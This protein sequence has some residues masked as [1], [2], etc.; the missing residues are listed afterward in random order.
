MKC[1]TSL[2]S[3]KAGGAGWQRTGRAGWLGVLW[4]VLALGSI[5]LG[6]GC[7]EPVRY[8]ADRPRQAQTLA[9]DA[10]G[11]RLAVVNPESDSLS[12]LDV[13]AR[14]LVRE[15]PL[16]PR[17]TAAAD[18]RFEPRHA[19]R[20]VDLSPDGRLAYVACQ[21]SGRLL[22]VDVE[23]AAVL[24]ELPLGAEPVTALVH[25]SGEALYV[26]L[27]QSGE[28]V[29][30]PLVRGL[31]DEASAL[32]R[33]TTDRPFGLSLDGA[34]QRL[35][36]TRFLLQPGLDVLDAA[37]LAP[38]AQAGLDEVKPR[39]NKLLAHGVPRGVYGAA[40]RPGMTGEVWLPHLLLAVDVA[41][42]ELDFESTV[43]PT[44]S[45][46]GPAGEALSG[47][48]LSVDSRLPKIDGAFAD[49]V[50]GPRAVAFTPDGSLAL[51]VNMS[52]EDVLVVDAE[53][54]V[55]AQLLRPLPGDLPEGIVV[56]PDG[57]HAFIDQR[58]S[59]DVAV[60]KIAEPGAR[61]RVQLEPQAIPRLAAGDPMPSEL[62]LGQRLFY[63]A[64]SAEFP[65]TKN[66]WVACASCHLEGR[67][68]GVT[69]LFSTGPRDTPSNAG[70]TLG[71]GFLMRNATRN[72]MQQ[73]D[74]T[75]RIEQGGDFDL[76]RPADRRLLDAL[77]AYVDRAVPLPRSPEIDV[78][79][80]QPSAA[81]MR[82]QAVWTKLQCER[83]HGGPRYTD[84][85]SG[86]PGLDL[87]G[88]VMLHDVGSCAGAP[89]PDQ[90]TLARDG[91]PRPACAF[92]TPGLRG[93]FDTAPYLHDGRAATL[94]DV[95]DHFVRFFKL[96]EPT[97]SERADL[98][99]FLR[100]L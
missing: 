54:R 69:W 12:I 32:R 92:D 40:V 79:T 59:G 67:S 58:A 73:Y 8:P 72:Q 51:V 70:G 95:I 71:T 29:R 81:A 34:G 86:N 77:T 82:G 56:S 35:Y 52:S 100:S 50:S 46:R 30:L 98:A 4:S 22:T 31:P 6:G 16:G 18:G 93:A 96:P 78:R 64:N 13:E 15:I 74:E 3:P 2:S 45:L 47:G 24:Q 20:G 91:A 1:S 43:F 36:V 14:Q 63:S 17:P 57:R 87:G 62:R 83:C 44:V 41:Q 48:T 19:P 11:Q 10:A 61:D 7:G 76:S 88:S 94:E 66:F 53:R 99:A 84:S 49:I 27:Y 38:Q 90:P 42:P 26:A 28:V 75:I 33:R 55:Q 21:S 23:S 5:S 25:P 80:G 68:D 9:L 65:I 37:T 97:A 39:G 85:G 89:F 60:L